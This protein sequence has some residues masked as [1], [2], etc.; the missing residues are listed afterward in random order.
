MNR[1]SV[2]DAA[3][4]PYKILT[5]LGQGSG[6]AVYR[7]WDPRLRREVALK[8]LHERPGGDLKRAHRFI[9]EARA[10]SALNHPNIVTVLDAAFDSSTPYI[11]S[12]LIDGRTLREEIGSS[13]VPPKR[14]LDLATQIADGLSAAHDAGIVHRDLKPENIMITRTGRVKIV[15]FGLASAVGFEPPGEPPDQDDMQTRTDLGLRA[16]TIPYMSPEQARGT[17][18]DYRSDQ[19][20]FGLILFEMAVGRPAFRRNSPAA[21]LD[22]IINDEPQNPP[23]LDARMP[24]MFR[25][26]V[27]RCL[28]KDRAERYAST[29][30]LHRDLRTLRDRLGE[31][32]SAAQG[33]PAPA[34]RPLWQRSL[35]ATALLAAFGAGAILS[36]MTPRTEERD[37]SALK[38]TP[39]TTDPGYQ[40]FPAWSPDGQTIAYAAD[41][42]DTLQIFTR[43]VSSQAAAQITHAPYDCRY[44]FWSPDGNRIYY[45]SLARERDSIWSVSAAGGTPQV[46]VENASRGAIAPDGRAIAFLSR[47]AAGGY[48]RRLRA[49]AADVERRRDAIRSVR[50][51][52][53]RRRRSGVLA[54]RRDA[55]HQRR[56]KV[57][58]PAAGGARLAILGRSAVGR[59]AVPPL[60]VVV[61]C[62]AARHQ[63]RLAA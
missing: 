36:V 30:D 51:P 43:R 33:P 63:L 13:P 55:R 61:R 25:W 45:V 40:G 54:R 15:D 59:S 60:R 34:H 48:R 46:V 62:R 52:A 32:T 6:G 19:F 12:E 8:I 18:S 50:S 17:A 57:D 38:F 22:A 10:A 21:T 26:I 42:N 2:H 29:T 23:A 9:A 58:Q 3:V 11:V 44:P 31:L 27:E 37:P 20:S 35:L 16:G 39:F 14:L 47:R 1:A 41:V 28:A 53:L 4:G 24:P 7:A 5:R 56:A 49:V